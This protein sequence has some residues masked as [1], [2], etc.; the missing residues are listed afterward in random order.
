[1]LTKKHVHSMLYLLLVLLILAACGG[2]SPEAEEASEEN[3]VLKPPAEEEAMEEDEAMEEEAMEEEAEDV[4]AGMEAEGSERGGDQLPTPPRR[5]KVAEDREQTAVLVND[6][7]SRAEPASTEPLTAGEIDDNQQWASYLAYRN[8]YANDDV[9]P[10]NVSQRR[11][12]IVRN[13]T[14]APLLGATLTIRTDGQFVT[15]LQTRSDGSA[16]FFPNAYL[17]QGSS[18]EVEA[19]L[20]GS[21][22]SAT[23]A[24]TGPTIL[25]LDTTTP[26]ATQLD[27]V[28]LLDAT[29]SMGD[30][31]AQ[32]KAN[33]NHI[34]AQTAALDAQPDIRLGMVAYRDEADDFVT[35]QQNFVSNVASF[36]TFLNSIEASGGGDYPEALNLALAEGIQD[37]SWRTTPTVKLVFLIADAPP[38]VESGAD[39][40]Y[41]VPMYAAAEQGI[42]IYPIASS[43]LDEQGE[44][45]FRQLAQFTNGRFLFLTDPPGQ[46]EAT[47]GGA[48]N[49]NYTIAALD[50]LV[51]EIIREEL[52]H[53]P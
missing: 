49:G 37:L 23:V 46:T 7:E 9:F 33:I 44:Y 45:I 47:T 16:L 31:I 6:S 24:T 30:E 18:Y 8:S 2:A 40:D 22:A 35:R 1:M 20:S 25:T 12:I 32:L 51:I 4:G 53:R 42:K 13:G 39:K 10:V 26:T 5:N 14:G 15:T 29:G 36:G 50:S 48:S 52:S 34:V 28:I 17:R 19:E 27:I 21:R 3:Q 41:T 11:Q 43:G 38:H